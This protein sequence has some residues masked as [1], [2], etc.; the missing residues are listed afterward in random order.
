MS[1]RSDTAIDSAGTRQETSMTELL[2]QHD[3][4]QRQCEA[5]VVESSTEGIVLDR[6]VFYPT[7]G[8]QPG[9]QGRLAWGESETPIVDTRWRRADGA[10]VHVPAD[11][12]LLPEV[13][14]QVVAAIDW[15]LRYR[16]MRMHTCL[17]LLGAVLNFPVTGGNIS[18]TKSRLDFDIPDA[19]D[20]EEVTRELNE[21]INA[22][23]PVTSRWI[24]E[25]DLDPGLVR[26]MSVKPPS[27]V[28]RIRLLD[29]PGVDLQPCGGTHV[30][31]TD[32]IGP[33]RVSKIEKKGRQNRRL[34]VVL[35]SG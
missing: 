30:R 28:G 7:G 33:A 32:E 2:F 21:L 1:D 10:V 23:H 11:E 6:T 15:D 4:Y 16:H 34:H 26:T 17:H 25:A 9:D 35:E 24:D 22:A 13:G 31:A 19:P 5:H 8:G 27:G 18:S 29:I 12:S 3:A 20:K 14:A